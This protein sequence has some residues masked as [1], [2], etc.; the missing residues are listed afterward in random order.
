MNVVFKNTL[1][2]ND[3]CLLRKSVGFYNI[4]EKVVK[5]AL[6]KSDFIISAF[7]NDIPVGMGRLITDGTQ[8]LIMD[9]I[10]HPDFQKK[11]IGR[12]LMDYILDFV[13]NMD[14]SQIFVQLLTE[15]NKTGFYEKLGFG[16]ASTEG[17][18]GMWLELFKDTNK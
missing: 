15:N 1:S 16:K 18:E 9:V 4:P 5:F 8:V 2:V 10:V 11:G 13:K 7:I 14:Y 6:E 12:T 3:Y 17:A